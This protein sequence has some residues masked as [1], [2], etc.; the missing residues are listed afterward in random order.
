VASVG[1]VIVGLDVTDAAVIVLKLTLNDKIGVIGSRQVKVIVAGG[2]AIE[3]DLEVLAAGLGDR[4]VIGVESQWKW[5]R[6]S[7]YHSILT[8]LGLPEGRREGNG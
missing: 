8:G 7:A 5:P 3:R 6:V 2:L 1:I 4:H